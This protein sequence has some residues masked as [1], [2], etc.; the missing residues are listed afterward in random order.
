MGPP[1]LPDRSGVEGSRLRQNHVVFSPRD[2]ECME[3]ST[4]GIWLEHERC[5]W[6]GLILGG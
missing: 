5:V 3:E 4:G 6:E 2:S 1:G